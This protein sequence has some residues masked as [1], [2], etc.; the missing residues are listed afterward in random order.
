V[1]LADERG[2]GLVAVGDPTLDF[3]AHRYTTGD[4]DRARHTSDLTPR[5]TITLHLD[6]RQNGIG[7]NSCGPALPEQYHLRAEP[8]V[9]RLR[10]RPLVPGGPGPQALAR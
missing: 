2:A 3:S 7:S 6:Y 10:L 9:F 1:A 5:P 8:F 4:L